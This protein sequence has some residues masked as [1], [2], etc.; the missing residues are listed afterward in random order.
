[1]STWQPKIGRHVQFAKSTP[2]RTGITNNKRWIPAVITNVDSP[3]QLDLRLQHYGTALNVP[4]QTA[5]NQITVWK[6]A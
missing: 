2:S 3:T 5:E 1:M 4:K 6:N